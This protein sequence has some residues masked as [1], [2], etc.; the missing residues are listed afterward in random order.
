MP[1]TQ[2]PWWQGSGEQSSTFRSHRVPSKPARMGDQGLTLVHGYSLSPS[3]AQL[4]G[5]TPTPFH[6]AQLQALTLAQNLPL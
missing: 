2:R 4:S 5:L 3:L 6:S 1:S